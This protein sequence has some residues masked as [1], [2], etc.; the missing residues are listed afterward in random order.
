MYAPA[1]HK[2]Y[3]DLQPQ[4]KQ[5]RAIEVFLDLPPVLQNSF[6]VFFIQIKIYGL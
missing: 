1:M 4:Q 5:P 3:I 2:V 6:G